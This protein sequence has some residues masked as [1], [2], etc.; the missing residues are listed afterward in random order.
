MEKDRLN[1]QGLLFSIYLYR[2]VPSGKMYSGYYSSERWKKWFMRK[3]CKIDV[4]SDRNYL[5]DM[6]RCSK[7]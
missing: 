3:G 1:T 7:K 5:C 6:W 2:T 4:T